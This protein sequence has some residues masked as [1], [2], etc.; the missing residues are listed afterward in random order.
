ML[1]AADFAVGMYFIQA[2]MSK[3]I[4]TIPATLPPALYQQAGGSTPS[5]VGTHST[6]TS[7]SFSPTQ[8]AFPSTIQRQY[9]GQT[10]LPFMHAD[11]SGLG[12]PPPP[13]IPARPTPSQLGSSAFG[14]RQ[15]AHWDVT[16]QEKQN[17]DAVFTNLDSK[18]Q[19][20]IEGDVAVPFMLSSKLSE[21]DLALIW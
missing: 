19:G 21:Q 13:P 20:Y 15:D 6:G 18:N 4:T 12:K 9:T 16:P 1:D 14:I 7:G 2:V 10:A 8:S 3:K 17:S 11:L 5:V